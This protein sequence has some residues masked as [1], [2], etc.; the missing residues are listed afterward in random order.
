VCNAHLLLARADFCQL[1]VPYVHEHN[2]AI[3]ASADQQAVVVADMQSGNWAL[4][5]LD[6][7]KLPC[8][9]QVCDKLQLSTHE[10]RDTPRTMLCSW[11]AA[12]TV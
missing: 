1:L 7:I 10:W 2:T 4:M 3:L 12:A 5:A 9:K 8:N 6:L 11:C